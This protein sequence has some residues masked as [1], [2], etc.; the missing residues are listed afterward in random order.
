MTTIQPVNGH[1]LIQPIEHE[2]F[3]ATSQN[4]YE[5]RGI[6]LAVAEGLK[7]RVTAGDR[8]YFDAWLAAKFP[9]EKPN[10]YNWFVKWEDVRSI[11]Y[12]Q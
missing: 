5:E 12:V 2:S 3:V 8:V 4:T 7:D 6:V 11:E 10:S 9:G 1:L